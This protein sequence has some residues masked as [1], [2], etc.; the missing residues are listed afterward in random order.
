MHTLTH[1]TKRTLYALALGLV[2]GLLTLGPVLLAQ[3]V[4]PQPKFTAYDS[5]GDPCSSCKLYSYAAGTSSPL[6]TYTD[7]ALGTPNANP[8]VLDSAGRATIFVSNS[9]SYKFTLK[10]SADVDIWTVDNVVGQLSGV[11]TIS[12]ANTRGLVITRAG[13]AAGMSIGSTGGSGDT[14][15]FEATTAGELKIQDEDGSPRIELGTGEAIDLVT[16]GTVR[17]SGGL[18]DVTG[19]G[20]HTFSASG[21]GANV[22]YVRN[23]TA[24]TGNYARMG[25]GNDTSASALLLQTHASTYTTSG[26]NVADGSLI[27]QGLAG[28]LNLAAGHAS[29]DVRFY[30]GGSTTARL[31]I[32]QDGIITSATQPG[33]LA[34]NSATDAGV[35]ALG[36][37]VEFDAEV[38]DTGSDYNDSTDTFTAPATGYY[39][40]CATVRAIAATAGASVRIVTS[41]R[42]Y[43]IGDTALT[44][45]Y[46]YSGC[47]IADMDAA[48]T[49]TVGIVFAAGTAD[50]Y[51][52]ATPYMTHFSGRMMP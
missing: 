1:S 3:S 20:D 33:F 35:A 4:M 38:Y 11:V 17:V 9:V 44:S 47:V 31:T 18:L 48:D 42:S 6:D 13:A 28:G 10:T 25:V 43:Y 16:T 46:V 32:D 37:T 40:L 41:N 5:N 51:G 49:A 24:G 15:G 36:G 23:T 30:T 21:T 19:F 26:Y 12:A 39:S 29:G 52:S 27:Y 50:I 7:Y 8:V 45:N 14:F 2:V 34:Y 22:L